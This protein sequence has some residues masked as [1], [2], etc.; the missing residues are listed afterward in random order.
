MVAKSPTHN[1]GV[2]GL[3]GQVRAL[4]TI[5]GRI[6]SRFRFL[7][8]EPGAA[9]SRHLACRVRTPR[10]GNHFSGVCRGET[11]RRGS[12]LLRHGGPGR[13]PGRTGHVRHNE[14]YRSVAREVPEPSRQGRAAH[15]HGPPSHLY[16]PGRDQDYAAAPGALKRTSGT[17]RVHAETEAQAKTLNLRFL[18][19]PEG[20]PN[21]A[22]GGAQR[23]PWTC[24]SRKLWSPV[25]GET[26]PVSPLT[27]LQTLYRLRSRGC[28]A[29]HPWLRSVAPPGLQE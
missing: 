18:A 28:A 21:V 20:R 4:R 2:N 12:G 15:Q 7:D 16:A 25:R 23:N 13:Q 24:R 6:R 10:L 19:A 9:E 3:V 27:G 22:R 14:P 8:Y 5:R 17:S 29:L 26:C 11:H 1:M